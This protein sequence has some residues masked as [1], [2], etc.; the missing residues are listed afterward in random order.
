M[1][2]LVRSGGKDG[3]FI[4]RGVVCWWGTGR[5]YVKVEY[6]IGIMG[7]F[8]TCKGGFKDGNSDLYIY[9]AIS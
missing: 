9:C 5:S 4:G 6:V 1:D 7:L 8:V 2:L 3:M